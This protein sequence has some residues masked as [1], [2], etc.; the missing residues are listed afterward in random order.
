MKS[1]RSPTWQQALRVSRCPARPRVTS[2]T[3]PPSSR[4]VDLDRPDTSIAIPAVPEREF[5][6]RRRA[7]RRHRYAHGKKIGAARVRV[8]RSARPRRHAARASSERRT[9]STER[10][11]TLEQLRHVRERGAAHTRPASRLP[12]AID[13]ER[14]R[15]AGHQTCGRSPPAT[16]E[17]GRQSCYVPSRMRRAAVILLLADRRDPDRGDVHDTFSETADEPMHLIGRTGAPEHASL[18]D[19]AP[20]PAPARAS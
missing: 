14:D 5:S 18:H 19:A 15:G 1:F 17:H 16:D 7:H 10:R 20:E 4:R 13:V 11:L 3:S 9:S 8:R 2:S 12:E 6:R